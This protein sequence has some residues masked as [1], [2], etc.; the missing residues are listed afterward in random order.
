M[1]HDGLAGS[2]IGASLISSD[3]ATKDHALRAYIESE[4]QVIG[5]PKSQPTSVG[6]TRELVLQQHTNRTRTGTGPLIASGPDAKNGHSK[7][8]VPPGGVI[9][10]VGL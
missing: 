9:F 3:M 1:S 7:C 2:P 4:N 6:A 10:N 5:L 8:P